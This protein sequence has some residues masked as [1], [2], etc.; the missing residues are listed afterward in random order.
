MKYVCRSQMYVYLMTGNIRAMS[1]C[2]KHCKT[3]LLQ[4]SPIQ[5]KIISQALLPGCENIIHDRDSLH[6]CVECKVH[7]NVVL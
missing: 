6:R 5:L 3:H 4:K 1:L 2:E 7:Y